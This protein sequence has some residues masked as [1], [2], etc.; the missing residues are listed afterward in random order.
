MRYKTKKVWHHG[1]LVRTEQQGGGTNNLCQSLLIGQ[2]R[3]R[4]RTD[5]LVQ[6]SWLN[7]AGASIEI[8]EVE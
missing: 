6:Q 2:A 4:L 8:K 7:V 5:H 3:W 1:S